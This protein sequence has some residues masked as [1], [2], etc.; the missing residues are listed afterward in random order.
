MKNIF[1]K[2]FVSSIFLSFSTCSI[3]AAD[4]PIIIG[5]QGPQTGPWEYEGQMALKSCETAAQLINENGGILGVRP[6]DVHVADDMGQ[7]DGGSL[8]AIRLAS[9]NNIVGVVS[10]YGSSVCE[11]ASEIY[12]KK[13]IV[14][15]AYGATA[16]GLTQRGLKYFFRICGVDSSQGVFFA[17]YVP[18]I[19]EAERIAIMHDNTAFAIGVAEETKKAFQTLINMGKV[20][21]VY[22]DAI[23]PGQKDFMVPLTRVKETEPDILYFT[24]YYAEAAIIAAQ[25]R[26]LGI[27]CPFVGGNAAINDEFVRIA[28]LDIAKGCFMTQEPMPADLPYD[29]SRQ[30]LDAYKTKYGEVPSSPW[31]VYAADALYI[32]AYAVDKVGS[33]DSAAI[34]EYLRNEVNGVPGVT[35]SIGFTENGD[36]EGVPYLMYVINNRGGF[37]IYKP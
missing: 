6:I 36:R 11:S 9:L 13:K 3:F 29:K 2:I 35:G 1:R 34:A 23:I 20:E 15:I 21:I 33:T 7:P 31:P 32:I 12:E 37:D 24:G 14:N 16:V 19:F 30:F 22:Y 10:T 25:A 28:G 26:E 17:Q 8:A 4:M 18:R 27:D 5:L